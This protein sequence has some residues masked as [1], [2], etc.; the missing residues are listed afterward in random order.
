M[1][2]RLTRLV[3]GKPTYMSS[4]HNVKGGW[5]DWYPLPPKKTLE[6]VKVNKQGI[7]TSMWLT[8]PIREGEMLRNVRLRV[9]WDGERNPSIDAPLCDFFGSGLALTKDHP[10]FPL[11]I[12]SGGYYCFFQMP[13]KKA[14]L[15]VHNPGPEDVK[16]LYYMIGYRQQPVTSK[17]LRFHA[18]FN[19]ENPTKR[20][21]PYFLLKAKGLGQLVGVMLSAQGSDKEKGFGFLEGNFSM[22]ADSKLAYGSTGT[23]DYFLSGWY[24][25]TGEFAAPF[26][27]LTTK[28]GIRTAFSAYR[29]HIADPIPFA[30]R[31]EVT[32][33]HGERDEIDGDYSSMAYWYQKEPHTPFP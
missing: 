3:R 1:L 4:T 16:S 5:A 14:R 26:H 8:F 7:I 29:F 33:H 18:T 17:D 24:F 13:F 6:L 31:L 30:R 2:E 25:R 11:G 15:E 19:R 23:E 27:G 12:T 28:D 10:A 22:V 32:V 20:G 21:K 9:Y